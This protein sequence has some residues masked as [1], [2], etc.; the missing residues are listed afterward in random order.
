MSATDQNMR[1]HEEINNY[2]F[3]L[4]KMAIEVNKVKS[5]NQDLT[6]TNSVIIL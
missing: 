6:N 4:N 5:E 2:K 1:L 3:M